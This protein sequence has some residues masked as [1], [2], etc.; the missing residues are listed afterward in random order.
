MGV[1]TEPEG[2][3]F[4]TDMDRIERSNLNRQFLFR[5]RDVG[6]PKSTTAA[7]A[8]RVM[9][10]DMNVEAHEN[11]VGPKTEDFYTDKFFEALD[12]VANALDNIEARTYVD[13]RCVYYCKP[14]LES[15]TLGTLGNTQV[16][17]PYVTESYSTTQVIPNCI[18]V[19]LSSFGNRVN[20]LGSAREVNSNLHPKKFPECD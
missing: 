15:G 18:H 19:L 6:N 10:P 3:V 12:G 9:N 5:N 7:K 16:V 20:Y 2:K 17:L 4:V 8:A 13:R 1:G 11:F 14:L